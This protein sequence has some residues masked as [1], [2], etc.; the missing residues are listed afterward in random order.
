ML[1][2]SKNIFNS[3]IMQ[4]LAMKKTCSV[5]KKYISFKNLDLAKKPSKYFTTRSLFSGEITYENV[6]YNLKKLDIKP[7]QNV[8]DLPEV[9]IIKVNYSNPYIIEYIDYI[10]EQEERDGKWIDVAIYFLMEMS[11]Y[12][13]KNYIRKNGA[14]GLEELLRLLET[15]IGGNYAM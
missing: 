10:I 14:L 11:E 12:D 9:Q 8:E 6:V 15:L 2:L 13:L 1:S 7:G 5:N 4:G 3:K